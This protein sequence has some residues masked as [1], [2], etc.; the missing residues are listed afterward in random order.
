MTP[1]GRIGLV[2]AHG[3]IG[4][5]IA[6]TLRNAST[7]L[8][9]LPRIE[10]PNS[11]VTDRTQRGGGHVALGYERYLSDVDVVIN[12]AGLA[13]PASSD[14]AALE[15]SNA[16]LP[17]ALARACQA[18]GVR[19][20][21]HVSSAAVQGGRSLLDSTDAVE[22]LTPYAHSK[23]MGEVLLREIA[24]NRPIEICSYRPTSVMALDRDTT[25]SLVR[26]LSRRWMPLVG[27]AEA[28][29]PLV[30]LDGTAEF[31]AHLALCAEQLPPA[32]VHP[33][34]GVTKQLAFELLGGRSSPRVAPMVFERVLRGVSSVATSVAPSIAAQ[35]RRVDLLVTGQMIDGS[36]SELVG[37]RPDLQCE[38]HR[39]GL[40]GERVRATF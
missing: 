13:A 30:S 11:S 9:V 39:L 21:V 16:A 5:S 25:K 38:H 35:L 36:A 34:V 18:A 28:P 33:W 27:D 6:Q 29:L 17:A 10:L 7:D 23:A 12:A 4:A 32:I 20:L 24:E 22:P 19:R 8:V 40:I 1:A 3:L 37:F 15:K 31:V 14:E 26:A 2:G